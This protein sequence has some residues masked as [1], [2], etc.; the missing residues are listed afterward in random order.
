MLSRF[1]RTSPALLSAQTRFEFRVQHEVKKFSFVVKCSPPPSD[2]VF[3][4]YTNEHN[5]G[6]TKV[7]IIVIA[8][9]VKIISVA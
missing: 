2:V 9:Q 6:F 7:T 3:L 4:Q 8:F 5:E 1:T